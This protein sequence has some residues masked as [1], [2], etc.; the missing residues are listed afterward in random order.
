MLSTAD[1]TIFFFWKLRNKAAGASRGETIT[2]TKQSIMEMLQEFFSHHI[3]SQNVWP[4]RS[5]DLFSYD[6]DLWFFRR[7]K[8]TSHTRTEKY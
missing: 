2:H 6:S 8:N 3:I 1:N 5:P 7:Y 4:P